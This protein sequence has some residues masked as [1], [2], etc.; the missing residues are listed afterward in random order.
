MARL[1]R[2]ATAF[3]AVDVG[4]SKAACLI[5]QVDASGAELQ[6]RVVGPIASRAASRLLPDTARQVH[7]AALDAQQD[8]E[9]L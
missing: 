9:S 1:K 3:A 4:A 2:D 6:R 7:G 8:Q 5:A